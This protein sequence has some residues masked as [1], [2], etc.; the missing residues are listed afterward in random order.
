MYGKSACEIAIQ[1]SGWS[2]GQ[3]PSQMGF[4]PP[5][6]L[7]RILPWAWR[8]WWW[9]TKIADQDLT[10]FD[11]CY[12]IITA[13][14]LYAPKLITPSLLHDVI[15]MNSVFTSQIFMV[16][17]SQILIALLVS[18]SVK[19]EMHFGKLLR[20]YLR[21]VTQSEYIF[22]SNGWCFTGSPFSL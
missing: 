8:L 10:P 12:I 5:E 14:S 17:S 11:R 6:F 2:S 18:E 3:Y 16:Y 15:T 13:S 19:Q 20:P 22:N 21:L 4:L 9:D 7:V 1:N